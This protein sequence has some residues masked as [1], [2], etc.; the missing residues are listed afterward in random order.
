MPVQGSVW[1]I[2]ICLA[3]KRH[4]LKLADSVKK[5]SLEWFTVEGAAL[6]SHADRV[7]IALFLVVLTSCIS[8]AL[9]NLVWHL[10]ECFGAS[11]AVHYCQYNKGDIFPKHKRD[12]LHTYYTVG[13]TGSP[14]ELCWKHTAVTPLVCRN[15]IHPVC[16]FRVAPPDLFRSK[17]Y[18]KLH[19]PTQKLHE[20]STDLQGFCQTWG[21]FLA[22]SSKQLFQLSENQVEGWGFMMKNSSKVVPQC[23]IRKLASCISSL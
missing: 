7:G 10:P 13:E 5:L 2:N 23:M 1:K 21:K 4:H 20:F 3:Q 18:I 22:C 12:L 17:S 8:N 6:Y 9:L 16:I 11:L 19:E 14:L 15:W